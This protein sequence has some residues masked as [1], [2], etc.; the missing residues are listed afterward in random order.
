MINL[1]AEIP[2]ELLA[3]LARPTVRLSGSIDEAAVASF[4]N[5]LLPVLD[6]PGSIVMEL[7]SSGEMPKWADDWLKKFVSFVKF[8]GVT[9][10]SSARHSSHRRR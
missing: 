9:C 8:T 5:Q 6:V 2:A 10:G 7:F 4:L 3:R 1:T